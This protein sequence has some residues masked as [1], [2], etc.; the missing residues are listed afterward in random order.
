MDKQKG[1][2][3][4]RNIHLILS[5]FI[6]IPAAFVYGFSPDGYFNI[7]EI[8]PPTTDLK[9]V[10]RALMFLYLGMA[11]IW[12]LGIFK[13]RW[14]TTATLTNMIFMGG[15]GIGRSIS[16]LIDG[17]PSGLFQVGLIGELILAAYAAIQLKISTGN[18]QQ[19]S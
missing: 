19:T 12:I 7:L 5:V 1:A 13:S 10:M 9:S 16:I 8:T 6:I 17:M 15:L 11:L 3:V 14:W 2:G 18:K 4:Q